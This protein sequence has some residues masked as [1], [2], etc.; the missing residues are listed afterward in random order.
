[1]NKILGYVD[2]GKA[3]GAELHCGGGRAGDKGFFVE[4]AVF[5]GVQ[6][7]HTIAKEEIFGP[8]MSILKFSSTEEVI[9]RANNSSYGLGAGLVTKSIDNAIEIS[10]ALRVG[11]VYVNSYDVFSEST[12][13]GGYKDSG[14]GREVGKEG[15][16]NYLEIK[17]VIIKRPDHAIP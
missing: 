13:F 4:P 15:L 8:V 17:N 11:T 3:E 2:K 14:M 12:S 5:S 1:M 10:N 16:K 7:D 9:E 6:D